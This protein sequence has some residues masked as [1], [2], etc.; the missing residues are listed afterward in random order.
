M[1]E[2]R[3]EN[4]K[5]M[6]RTWRRRCRTIEEKLKETFPSILQDKEPKNKTVLIVIF[7]CDKQLK[8]WWCHSVRLFVRPFVCMSRFFNG[9]QFWVIWSNP[10]L[11][12]FKQASSTRFKHASSMLWACFEL[13]RAPSPGNCLCV[14]CYQGMGWELAIRGEWEKERLVNRLE[15]IFWLR[16][17][18]L[19]IICPSGHQRMVSWKNWCKGSIPIKDKSIPVFWF[20]GVAKWGPRLGNSI[21]VLQKSLLSPW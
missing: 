13:V 14:S 16:V 11:I 18:K 20:S 4:E 9:V 6:Q 19:Y 15:I 1:K 5:R 8:K 12:D 7:S 3:A 10:S 2:R 17:K 21:S